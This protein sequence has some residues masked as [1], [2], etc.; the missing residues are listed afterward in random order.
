MKEGYSLQEIR[1]RVESGQKLKT[2][3]A[4]AHNATGVPAAPSDISV[5]TNETLHDL[6]ADF[7]IVNDLVMQYSSSFVQVSKLIR[8]AAGSYYD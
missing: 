3:V 1:D 8:M 7:V 4:R 2:I 5:F 6:L